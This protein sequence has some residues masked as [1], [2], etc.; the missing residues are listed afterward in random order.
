MAV[1]GA[2]FAPSCQSL[3]AGRLLPPLTLLALFFALPTLGAGPDALEAAVVNALERRPRVWVLMG[4]DGDERHASLRSGANVV[5][6]LR[7]YPDLQVGRRR[8]RKLGGRPRGRSGSR[9]RGRG[10]QRWAAEGGTAPARRPP[11]R[12]GFGGGA[13][14]GLGR[15]GAT[16]GP[17]ALLAGRGP[18]LQ[19]PAARAVFG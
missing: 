7:H 1:D 18:L 16:R 10:A 11:S 12:L 2:C 15:L 17:R 9:G 6:K 3:F 13:P 8:P 19:A 14:F 4:G 5:A